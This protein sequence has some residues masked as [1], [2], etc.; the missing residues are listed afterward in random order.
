M[1]DQQTEKD[2]ESAGFEPR[3][4]SAFLAAFEYRRPRTP[5]WQKRMTEELKL[6]GG[7][8]SKMRKGLERITPRS[9][10]PI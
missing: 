3:A 10:S 2:S 9:S 5:G 7:Y 4:Y 8:L 6:G 1:I